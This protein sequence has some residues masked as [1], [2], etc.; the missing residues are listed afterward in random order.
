MTKVF[1]YDFETT[2]L[3]PKQHAAIQ[4]GGILEIDGQVVDVFNYTMRPY[5]DDLID[6]KAL[7]INRRTAAELRTFE[8]PTTVLEQV[9]G[10]LSKHI[11]VSNRNDQI[12]LCGYNNVH[13][14]DEFMRQWFVKAGRPKYD[15][16]NYFWNESLDMRVCC[17]AALAGERP[18]MENF[19]LITVAR[20]FGITVDMDQAHDALYD[21]QL[22]R[23]LAYRVRVVRR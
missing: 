12:F 6:G 2:G 4:I 8:H 16:M 19:K 10:R 22:V 13:F 14:D 18:R 5:D 3:D 9:L 15:F 21:A 20:H 23:E 1:Y 7:E 17:A 11:T